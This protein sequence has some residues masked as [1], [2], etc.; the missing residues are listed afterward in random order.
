M[1]KMCSVLAA[2]LCAALLFAACGSKPAAKAHTSAEYAE[3]IAASR[4]DEYNEYYMIGMPGEDGG[5]TAVKGGVEEWSAEDLN[6]YMGEM[7]M[8]LLGLTPEMSSSYA[9]T[10]SLMMT[11]AY[12]VAIVKPA[13]GQTDAVKAALETYVEGQRQAF[14]LYLPDQYEIAKAATVTVADSGEVILVCS[15]NGEEILASIKAA[16]AA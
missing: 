3:M 6:S 16:L 7:V 12:G 13:E 4:A 11:Q 9:A 10:A 1:K 8:P 14:E 15:E 5:Y 2:V